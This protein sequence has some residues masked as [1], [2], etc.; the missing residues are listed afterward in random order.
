[1][2]K[3][4]HPFKIEIAQNGQMGRFDVLLQVGGLKDKE[5]ALQ[6]AEMLAQWMTDN[7]QIGWIQR[8]Q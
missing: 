5:Q 2:I 4:S 8:A 3:V 7:G 6:F 1:M